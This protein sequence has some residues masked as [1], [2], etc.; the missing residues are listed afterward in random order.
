M[1][2]TLFNC[3]S[4]M[5]LIFMCSSFNQH[6]RMI[7]APRLT[8]PPLHAFA[9]FGAISLLQSQRAAFHIKSAVRHI[10]VAVA[11]LWFKSLI[12]STMSVV[13]GE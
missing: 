6:T 13:E 3:P 2:Y 5:S 4:D 12:S 7:V 10:V 9:V 1:T 11:R 8:R